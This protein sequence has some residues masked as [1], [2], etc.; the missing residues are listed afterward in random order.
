[1][2]WARGVDRLGD[3]LLA[4][5]ALAGDEDR[6]VGVL[7]PVDQ[8][9]DLPHRRAR[10]DEAGVAEVAAEL[11]AGLLQVAPRR[12]ELFGPRVEALGGLVPRRGQLGVGALELLRAAAELVEQTRALD[13]DRGLVGERRQGRELLAE[14]E[15]RPEARLEVERADGLARRRRAPDR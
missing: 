4:G 3:D 15:A 1:A 10:A 9:V 5:A 14:A 8:R 12:R 11:G 2:A 13:R 7:D 6:D